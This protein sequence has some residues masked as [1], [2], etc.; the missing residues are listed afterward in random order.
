MLHRPT[1]QELEAPLWPV[2]LHLRLRQ[3]SKNVKGEILLRYIVA[4]GMREGLG[5]GSQ[6]RLCT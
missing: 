3:I 4:S 5:E 1:I 2:A 6:V